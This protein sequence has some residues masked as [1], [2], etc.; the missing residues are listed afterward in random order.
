MINKEREL[1]LFCLLLLE[2]KKEG[3]IKTQDL[4]IV[5]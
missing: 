1:D 5:T 2:F 3:N 4:F